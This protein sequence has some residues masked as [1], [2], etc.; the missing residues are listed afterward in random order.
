MAPALEG[1]VC[2]LRA[3]LIGSRHVSRSTVCN[4]WHQEA[5]WRHGMDTGLLASSGDSQTF[6]MFSARDA[7]KVKRIRNFADIQVAP[8]TV[9]GKVTGAA[10]PAQAWLE[11]DAT[12]TENAYTALQAKYGWQMVLLDFF[13]K[14]SGNFN[15]RQ[16]LG[17]SVSSIS[18]D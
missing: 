6:Y 9:S 3:V 11:D 10:L 16:L 15:K 4:H 17:F 7:G 2:A 8:C 12:I 13:S 14:L 5:Q 1:F 18:E